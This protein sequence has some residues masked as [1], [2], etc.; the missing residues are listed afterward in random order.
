MKQKTITLLLCILLGLFLGSILQ[1]A[2]RHSGQALAAPEMDRPAPYGRVLYT[3]SSA[4][5]TTTM[6][7]GDPAKTAGYDPLKAIF[8]DVGTY[9]VT[10]TL[11]ARL[12]SAGDI[13]TITEDLAVMP[14]NTQFVI[15]VTAIAPWMSLGLASTDAVSGSQTTCAIYQQTP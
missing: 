12:S 3:H 5:I 10:M 4:N 8:C 2:L 9:P 13:Y 15:T 1:V 11:Y 7:L 6:N 14:A